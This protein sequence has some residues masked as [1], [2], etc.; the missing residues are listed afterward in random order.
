MDELNYY[1]L[2]QFIQLCST[3]TL[4]LN[5]PIQ[6]STITRDKV[7]HM[8]FLKH[9]IHLS[10]KY[11]TNMLHI[12]SQIRSTIKDTILK[13]IDSNPYVHKYI[14]TI[15]E[16]WGTEDITPSDLFMDGFDS[17]NDITIEPS[18]FNYNAISE[19]N[20]ISQSLD[21]QL[22]SI[23]D[24]LTHNMNQSGGI[25]SDNI[26]HTIQHLFHECSDCKTRIEKYI[27]E[28]E[29]KSDYLN[30]NYSDIL[31][32]LAMKFKP[33]Y[34][35]NYHMETNKSSISNFLTSTNGE[36]IPDTIHIIFLNY[37][38]CINM[39]HKEF[40]Y[41]ITSFET[42][43]DDMKDKH[44][45]TDNYLKRLSNPSQTINRPSTIQDFINSIRNVLPTF[46]DNED[47]LSESDEET[48]MQPTNQP[49]NKE[50]Q[51][52]LQQPR[53]QP[54]QTNKQMKDGTNLS[55]SDTSDIIVTA[56]GVHS[57]Y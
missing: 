4:P 57:F 10:K 19:E 16:E 27:A 9:G 5:Q 29:T 18:I 52:E 56:R 33:Q 21:S 20:T 3:G 7:L 46:S 49:T 55:Q 24:I 11:D 37:L 13:L 1:D 15:I 50:E 8:S 54:R 31:M 40:D 35:T 32:D 26:D 25:S 47:S 30:P 22:K 17:H 34:L 12:L 42:L 44:T 36:S 48:F 38:L 39:I 43:L 51:E 45:L 41:L 53:Q 2:S 23:E 14:E 6:I 28:L